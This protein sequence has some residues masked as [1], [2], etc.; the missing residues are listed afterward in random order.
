[1]H[2]SLLL[3]LAFLASGCAASVESSPSPE[4]DPDPGLVAP[5]PLTPPAPAVVVVPPVCSDADEAACVAAGE[6]CGSRPSDSA[7]Y[8]FKACYEDVE[9]DPAAVQACASA[10]PAGAA[11][12]AALVAC[13]CAC[14]L[15]DATF[16]DGSAYGHPHG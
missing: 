11:S 4:A 10:H 5:E 15:F 13:G 14:E 1:M 8:A 9:D 2:R 16:C 6:A 12:W 7:C 3:A